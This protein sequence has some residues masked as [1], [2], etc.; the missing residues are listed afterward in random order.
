MH[1]KIKHYQT[2]A[3]KQAAQLKDVRVVGMLLFVV[4]VLLVSWSGVKAI[5]AN[6]TLQRQISV[7]QQQNAVKKLA[8]ENLK[9]QNDYFNTPQYLELAARQDFGLAA[10][11]ETVLIVPRATAI[12]HT[13]ELPQDKE[14]G[15]A[16]KV[17]KPAYQRNF[18][19]WVDFF[20]HR[21]QE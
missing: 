16:A 12:A 4:I 20:M 13:I 14:P 11:G 17:K 8:N 10:P 19:A 2:L 6:Y 7:L 3:I 5:E 1:E 9:L 21:S 15:D 18:Q